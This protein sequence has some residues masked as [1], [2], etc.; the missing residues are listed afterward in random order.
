[1]KKTYIQPQTDVIRILMTGALAQ[2]SD[3]DITANPGESGD[4][5]EADA[6]QNPYRYNVWDEDWREKDE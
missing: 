2:M 6:R 4:P 3:P 5:N 1:M